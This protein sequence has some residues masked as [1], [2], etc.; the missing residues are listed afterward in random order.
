MTIAR[1]RWHVAAVLLA[2]LLA[3]PLRADA[4]VEDPSA[5][6]VSILLMIRMAPPHAR[7]DV[8]YGD[9]YAGRSGK[10]ARRRAAED[11]ARSHGLRL[12]SQW[13]MPVIGIECFVL[14]VPPDTQTAAVVESVS[15]DPRAV[16]AQPLQIF[17]GQ[18]YNDPL[19]DQQP[20]A[21]AWRLEALHAAATGRDVLIAQIDS[22]VETD[23]PDLVGQ[24]RMT[25]NTV[26]A[27]PMMVGV[28]A[29]VMA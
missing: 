19:F 16:W 2:A 18:S 20:V 3:L 15:R 8:D 27:K 21:L 29:R 26:A 14:Q 10:Q 25:H 6:D 9:G 12:V 4:G 24:I 5:A 7:P 13:P 17:R 11:I 22:G 28:Q 1:R 23:H